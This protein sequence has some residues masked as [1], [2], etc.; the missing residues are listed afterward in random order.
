MPNSFALQG[1]LFPLP[2]AIVL[3]GGAG[4]D[5]I[6]GPPAKTTWN[7]TGAG[8]GDVAGVTFD[9]IE[10]V[11]GAADNEDTFAFEAAGSISG[12]V[13]GGAGGFDTIALVSGSFSVT[14]FTIT[15]ADVRGDHARWRVIT[16][17]GLE[18]LPD[19][20]AGAKVVDGTAGDDTIII[21][22]DG[23]DILVELSGGEDPN[24]TE[25]LLITS[26]H[27]QRARR[28]RHD[29]RPVDLRRVL[30]Q[31]DHQRRR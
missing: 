5:V 18:P 4:K 25:P 7:I 15:G 20:T 16:Y 14:T 11:Q 13:D 3:H 21:R 17:T 6:R 24:F 29:H 2:T 12:V 9:Q 23:G 30:R 28:Q 10:D 1:S 19:A 22:D 8:S 27:G 31:P 26:H